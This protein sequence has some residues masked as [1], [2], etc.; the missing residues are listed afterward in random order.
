[1]FFLAKFS[2]V[3]YTL[4]NYMASI[5]LSYYFF[6]LSPVSGVLWTLFIEVV[7][8]IILFL[9]NGLSKKKLIICLFLFNVLFLLSAIQQQIEPIMLLSYFSKTIVFIN[10]I[11]IAQLFTI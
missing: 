3:N 8:Y 10:A 4:K 11:L 2:G 9:S 6:S 5:S 7:F 1:M